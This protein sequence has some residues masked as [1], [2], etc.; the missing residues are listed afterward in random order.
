M[1]D[2]DMKAAMAASLADSPALEQKALAND[3]LA[4][5]SLIQPSEGDPF[6]LR[7]DKVKGD[8]FCFLFV[9]SQRKRTYQ[10]QMI[11]ACAYL[12]HVLS[13]KWL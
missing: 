1:I 11:S 9:A 6:R 3:M 12:P 5:L 13:S 2:P 8:G 4:Q 10:M 7:Q